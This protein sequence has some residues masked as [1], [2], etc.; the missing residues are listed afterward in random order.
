[1]IEIIA[2]VILA[3]LLVGKEFLIYR[4][5]HDMLDRLMAKNLYDYKD[6]N[7]PEANHL[8]PQDLGL[9]DIELAREEIENGPDQD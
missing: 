6:T 9:E 3:I 7:Q 8:E 4:E 1:M 2:I 5:R